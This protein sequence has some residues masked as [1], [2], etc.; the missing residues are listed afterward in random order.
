LHYIYHKVFKKLKENIAKFLF[1]TS[2]GK[3]GTLKMG[4]DIL[5]VFV[6]N[7]VNVGIFKTVGRVSI[8]YDVMLLSLEDPCH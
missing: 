6:D 3:Y 5:K 8:T 2:F 7:V 4:I 1:V